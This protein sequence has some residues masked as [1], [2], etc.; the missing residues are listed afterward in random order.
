VNFVKDLNCD[1]LKMSRDEFEAY[2]SGSCCP[3]PQL[4]N[5]SDASAAVDFFQRAL[6]ESRQLRARVDAVAAELELVT[7]SSTSDQTKKIREEA[8]EEANNPDVL[9]LWSDSAPDADTAGL[10]PAPMEPSAQQQP[11]G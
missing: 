1:S 8:L 3:P 7:S 2:T 11:T 5:G 6:V 4:V 9:G 10:L